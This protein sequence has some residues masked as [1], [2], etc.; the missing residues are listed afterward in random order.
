MTCGRRL[1]ATRS[2]SPC[3]PAG[4][5][6]QPMAAVQR[7]VT[8]ALLGSSRQLTSSGSASR[9]ERR[10]VRAARR[11]PYSRPTT[12]TPCKP[13]SSS[14]ASPPRVPRRELVILAGPV[15]LL[16]EAIGAGPRHPPMPCG[17]TLGGGSRQRAL[18]LVRGGPPVPPSSRP[19]SHARVPTRQTPAI[20]IG[21]RCE[22]SA[23]AGRCASFWVCSSGRRRSSQSVVF[24]QFFTALR[25]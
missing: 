17:Q 16:T 1:R 22:Q 6:A 23:A 11:R 24:P 12:H 20:G 9:L 4:A 19:G 13:S 3:S 18:H 14:S 21:A 8:S 5:R 7:G 2:W 10:C 25:S 15:R